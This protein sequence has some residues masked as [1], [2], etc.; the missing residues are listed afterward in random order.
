[1]CYTLYFPFLCVIQFYFQV[2]AVTSV[3]KDLL[4]CL[5]GPTAQVM[6]IS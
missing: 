1:M 4:W 3:L 6:R 5:L 2:I